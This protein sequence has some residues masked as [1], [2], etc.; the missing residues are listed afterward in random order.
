M[1]GTIT[2]DTGKEHDRIL[3]RD[4]KQK[5]V[6]VVEDNKNVLK[7]TSSIVE[8]LGYTVIST[9]TGDDAYKILEARDDIS[10]LLTDVML[11]GKINGPELAKLAVE[12]YPAIKIVFNSGYTENTIL[13]NGML[14]HGAVL[15]SKPFRIQQL[16]S[17]LLE[18]L[19]Q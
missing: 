9:T 18:L 17:T 4:P 7:L 6:L 14:D 11:P 13:H 19:N 10:L 15:I 12:K 5:T 1:E 3:S 16:A 2:P 8:N